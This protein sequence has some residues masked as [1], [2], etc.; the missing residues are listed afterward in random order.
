MFNSTK[1][2][3]LPN[4]IHYRNLTLAII[5]K[6]NGA[7]DL[8]IEVKPTCCLLFCP[9]RNGKKYVHNRLELIHDMEISEKKNQ[10]PVDQTWT[11]N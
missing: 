3:M 9:N 7:Y 11:K 2:T 6:F 1:S 4:I 10:K 8:V 5:F